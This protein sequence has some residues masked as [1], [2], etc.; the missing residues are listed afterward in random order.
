MC[1]YERWIVACIFVAVTFFTKTIYIL[2]NTGDSFRIV[3]DT[4][5]VE[6]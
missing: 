5:T 2:P 3:Y 4:P 6:G 1:V